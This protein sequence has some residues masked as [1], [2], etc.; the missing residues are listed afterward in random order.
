M[1]FFADFDITETE[2]ISVVSIS[3]ISVD[4]EHSMEMK[5]R[6]GVVVKRLMSDCD[7]WSLAKEHFTTEEEIK[8][9]NGIFDET[10]LQAGRL[11]LIP[12]KR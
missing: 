12:Q 6:P 2:Q 4:A 1:R 3:E 11:V 9:A 5:D 8:L 7:V 10:E